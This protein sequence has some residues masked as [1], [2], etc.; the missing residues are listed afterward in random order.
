MAMR[1]L[2]E[3]V[4]L[5]ESILLQRFSCLRMNLLRLWKQIACIKL[6]LTGK[7]STLRIQNTNVQF[8]MLGIF[9]IC[10]YWFVMQNLH[11]K[12]ANKMKDFFHFNSLVF[13]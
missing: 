6:R 4:M 10:L 2:T 11:F 5:L 8:F 13:Y 7:W 9:R 3:V 1:F 12:V